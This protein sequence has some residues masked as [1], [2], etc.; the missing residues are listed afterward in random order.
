M[1]LCG[2]SEEAEKDHEDRARRKGK[3]VEEEECEREKHEGQ[4]GLKGT[5]M[6]AMTSPHY[7]LPTA[8][9]WETRRS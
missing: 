9:D 4:Y 6:A 1:N 3:E 2:G 8:Q 7:A 5:S